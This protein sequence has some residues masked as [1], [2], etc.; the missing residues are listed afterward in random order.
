MSCPVPA[1]MQTCDPKCV[2]RYSE[3]ADIAYDCSDPCGNGDPSAFNKAT[4]SCKS[5]GVYLVTQVRTGQ[6]NVANN[7]TRCYLVQ[8]PE[9][10]FDGTG[11]SVEYRWMEQLQDWPQGPED[12]GSVFSKL[13]PD[14]EGPPTGFISD[15]TGTPISVYPWSGGTITALTAPTDSYCSSKPTG[16]LSHSNG[17]VCFG[18]VY[19]GTNVD[20]LKFIP[21]TNNA[22]R[23]D[24]SR[25]AKT[26][27]SRQYIGP[28][29]ISQ[30][31]NEDE[32]AESSTGFWPIINPSDG[33]LGCF[34]PTKTP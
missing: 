5:G 12:P 21:Y 25:L 17:R 9:P 10:F 8:F 13:E 31:Y 20:K 6:A 24:V 2:C 26:V 27:V 4:C 33:T 23:C 29:L 34:G 22:I 15:N 32:Y 1:D 28:G 14:M 3:C 16:F 19:D 11:R 18:A 30:Y 7:G